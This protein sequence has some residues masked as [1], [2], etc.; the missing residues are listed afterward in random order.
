MKTDETLLLA[1]LAR[2]NWLLLVVLVLASLPLQ[3]W[4]LTLGVASGG[5][6]AVGGY[7]WLYRS[8][9][10]ALQEGSG[11]ARR[12]QRGYLLRLAVLAVL[13]VILIAL[14]RVH[15]AGLVVGLSIVVINLFWATVERVF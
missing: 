12:F 15:P 11:A 14:V 1:R 9:V 2:R 3:R 10:R 6:V 5:L 7:Q 8:L 4:D 13:L